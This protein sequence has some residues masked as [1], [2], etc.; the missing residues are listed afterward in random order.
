[1]KLVLVGCINDIYTLL[2]YLR[3]FLKG[4]VYLSV[5]LMINAMLVGTIIMT[6]LFCESLLQ[7]LFSKFEDYGKD[8]LNNCK[9]NQS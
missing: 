3:F 2:V 9:I 5:C 8:I 4:N 6:L 1:M 7:L